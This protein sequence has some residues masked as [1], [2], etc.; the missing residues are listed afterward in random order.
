MVHT[1]RGASVRADRHRV[2]VQGIGAPPDG[3]SLASVWL[4]RVPH[5]ATGR[6]ATAISR[7]QIEASLARVTHARSGNIDTACGSTAQ[8]VRDFGN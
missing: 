2:E 8:G 5:L 6:G 1:I 3:S 4:S 7:T